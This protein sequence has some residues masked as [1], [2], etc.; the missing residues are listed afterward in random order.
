[1]T[2][3]T[4]QSAARRTC[5]A[6]TPLSLKRLVATLAMASTATMTAVAAAWPERPIVMT[7]IGGPGSPPDVVARELG[8]HVGRALGQPVVVENAGAGGGIVGMDQVRRAAPDGHRFV[9]SHTVPL[10]VNPT[11]F[12]SL[13][14]DPVRDFEPVSLLLGGPMI[15]VATPSLGAHSYAEVVAASTRK[16]ARL[17]YGSTGIATPSNIFF[18]L[19]KAAS[20][21]T[22]DHVPFKGTPGLAQALQTD[23][24]PLGMESYPVLQGLIASGKVIPIA[25]SGDRR[26]SALPAVPTFA[27]LGVS[28]MGIVWFAVLA[29]KGTAPEII[30]TMHREL[31]RAL[32][33]PEFRRVHEALGRQIIGSTPAELAATLNTEIPRWRNVIRRAGITVE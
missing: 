11:L 29:P 28:N 26:L 27:E 22:I 7:V 9:L 1:M 20:G 13:P 4:I 2:I 21:A 3:I 18:E 17:F 6:R 25:V 10:T 23:Q 5:K 8:E 30:A 16:G 31:T 33:L 24:V 14:Y 15:L 12:K 19:F 32:A